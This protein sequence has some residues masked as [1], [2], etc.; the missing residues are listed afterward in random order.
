MPPVLA[1]TVIP[2]PNSAQFVS[3]TSFASS[4]APGASFGATIT[5]KNVGSATWDSTYGLVSKNPDLNT[6]FGVGSLPVSGT[7]VPGAS[8]AFTHTF[9]APAAAGT[10]HF[11][12]RMSKAG[13]QFGDQT[14]DV[15]VVVSADAAHLVSTTEPATIAA[16]TDFYFQTTMLN[17]GTTSWSSAAGYSMMS[18]DPANNMTWGRNRNFLG[19]TGSY[20]PGVQTPIYG[21]CT[22]PMIPGTYAMQWQMDKNGVPFGEPTPVQMIT[23]VVGPDDSQYVSETGLPGSFVTNHPFSFSFVMKNIGTATWDSSYT[24]V[25]ISTPNF[26]VSSISATSTA[27]GSSCTFTT[28]LTTP[29]TPGVYH[30]QWRMKHNGVLFGQPTAD[31]VLT[32]T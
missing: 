25:P 16:G 22:A 24:L 29:A 26:G 32:V 31:A 1:I 19:G 8:F 27:P 18:I 11:S 30:I 5:M 10:Y 12:W 9:V 3:Q 14:P 2:A 6:N 20:A 17:T 13:A 23:V 4:I 15:V 7:V 21:L 28:T